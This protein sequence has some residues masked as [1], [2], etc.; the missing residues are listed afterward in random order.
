M[1]VQANRRDNKEYYLKRAKDSFGAGDRAL[2]TSSCNKVLDYDSFDVYCKDL[3][4]EIQKLI[5]FLMVSGEEFQR[6]EFKAGIYGPY[7][8]TIRHVLNA[9]EGH[10]ISGF[11]DGQNKPETPI[12]LIDDAV[13]EAEKFLENYPDTRKRFDSVAELIEGFETPHGMELLATVHWAATQMNSD[14]AKNPES[15]LNVVRDWNTRK[16][17][18]MKPEHVNAAWTHLKD[19]GWFELR[20]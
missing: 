16:A 17:A 1:L 5:Y 4:S 11:G 3:V 20:V 18:M 14:A 13:V 10:F 15:A 19:R 2:A 12:S 9:M 6:V 8:D 7:A